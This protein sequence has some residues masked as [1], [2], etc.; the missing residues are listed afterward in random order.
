M[1]ASLILKLLAVSLLKTYCNKWGKYDDMIVVVAPMTDDRP[2]NAT[3]KEQNHLS[4]LVRQLI[5]CLL[6]SLRKSKAGNV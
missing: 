2:P 5:C 3:R 1:C 6:V 4:A